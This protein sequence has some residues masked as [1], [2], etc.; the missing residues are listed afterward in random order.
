MKAATHPLRPL[1]SARTL[2]E[3]RAPST[4][5]HAGH[6]YQARRSARKFP[7]PEQPA[8]FMKRPNPHALRE[9]I[10]GMQNETL[11]QLELGHGLSLIRMSDGER[12]IFELRHTRKRL[13]GGE[14][15]QSRLFDASGN[16]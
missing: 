3:P 1:H 15:T 10:A 16:G 4:S 13:F 14:K 12:V 6:G 5:T 11:D 2:A 7:G 9:W 8:R